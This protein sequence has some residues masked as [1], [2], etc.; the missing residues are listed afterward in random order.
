MAL[1]IDHRD[2]HFSHRTLDVHGKPAPMDLFDESF[3]HLGNGHTYTVVGFVWLGDTDEW[4]IKHKRNGS[5]VECVRSVSNF[6]GN[7]GNGQKRFEHI[8]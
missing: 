8:Q 4:G 3:R 5:L 1:P 6:F 7:R 2:P